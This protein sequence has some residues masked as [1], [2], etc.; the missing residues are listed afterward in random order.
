MDQFKRWGFSAESWRGGRGEYWVMGQAVLLIAFALLPSYPIAALNDGW[1]IACQGC[2]AGLAIG[3]VGLLITGV[4]SLGANLTPLPHPRDESSLVTTG[5]YRLVR[6][7]I[8]SGVILGA[9]AYGLWQWSLSHLLGAVVLL[10]F[11]DQKARREEGWLADKFAD[12]A[13]YQ[14]QVKKL[15]P[16]IY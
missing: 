11:F 9:I 13:T 3:A 5:V 12:Y 15:I 8:Y 1:T 16:W 10:L 6:H 2:A 7:P 14:L 4:M